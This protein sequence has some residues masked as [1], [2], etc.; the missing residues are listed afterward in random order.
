MVFFFNPTFLI[1]IVGFCVCCAVFWVLAS[2]S[3]WAGAVISFANDNTFWVFLGI[4]VVVTVVIGIIFLL[5]KQNF[6]I[7]IL[8]SIAAS[9]GLANAWSMVIVFLE[10]IEMKDFDFLILILV[11]PLI[12]LV[13]A[14]VTGVLAVLFIIIGLVPVGVLFEYEGL[15]NV[16]VAISAVISSVVS[17][18][19]LL[20][21]TDYFTNSLTSI[22][23]NL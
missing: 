2:L 23:G 12:Y 15:N 8:I 17:V 20:N 21:V 22:F 1:A 7:G 19:I 14:A 3:S 9:L 10:N 13:S 4:L 6:G 16:P 5:K 11:G 18:L